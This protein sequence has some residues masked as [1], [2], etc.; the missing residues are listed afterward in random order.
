MPKPSFVAGGNHVFPQTPFLEGEQFSAATP[1]DKGDLVFTF[2]IWNQN[3]AWESPSHG[4]MRP[5]GGAGKLRSGL[6]VPI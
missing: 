6:N 5:S 4:M 1:W 2:G 3:Q